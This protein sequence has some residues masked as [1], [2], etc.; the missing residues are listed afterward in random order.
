MARHA[1]K[2]GWLEQPALEQLGPTQRGR[3][4]SLGED[5]YDDDDE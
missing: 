3:R 1:A 4:Q 2:L 5:V